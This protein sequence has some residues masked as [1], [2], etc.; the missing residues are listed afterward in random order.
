MRSPHILSTGVATLLATFGLFTGHPSLHAATGTWTDPSGGSWADPTNW[1]GGLIPDGINDTANFNATELSGP[2]VVSLHGTRIVGTLNL[3]DL[4]SEA[5]TFT[6]VGTGG[7]LILQSSEGTAS[8]NITTIGSGPNIF[9]VPLLLNSDTEISITTFQQQLFNGA[10]TGAGALTI[11]ANGVHPVGTASR[12]GQVRLAGIN[13]FTG[14][15]TI[16][17]GVRVE[18][19]RALSYGNGRVTV[20]AGGQAFLNVAGVFKNDFTLSGLGWD[21]TSN[22]QMGALRSDANSTLTGAITLASSTV[23][24]AS[25]KST[26]T[27]LI[28]G[29]IGEAIAGTNLDIGRWD[30]D[31]ADGIA[32]AA[33]GTFIISSK[34][35]YTGVTSISSGT[36]QIGNGS[37]TGDLSSSSA[38]VF[39]RTNTN[40]EP[41]QTATL[42]F[43]RSDNVLF[44]TPVSETT[45]DAGNR[46]TGNLRHS[47]TGTLSWASDSNGYSGTTTVDGR[48]GRLVFGTGG[49]FTFGAT[50]AISLKNR[51]DLE[52]NTSS[53]I[54]LNQT[55]TGEA[56]TLII[57]SGTGTLTIGG[58]TDNYGARVLVNSG[59]VVL[60]KASSSGIHAVTTPGAS[61]LG[62]VVTGGVV[63]LA[64]T[65]GNQIDDAAVVRL[66]GGTFDMNG[67][68]EAFDVLQGTAG[69]ITNSSP[70]PSTLQIGAVGRSDIDV[71]D[72]SFGG[73][74]QDGAGPISLRKYERSTLTLTGHNTYTGQT[75][76]EQGTLIVNGS[77]AAPGAVDIT[78]QSTLSG[79]GSLGHVSLGSSARVAPGVSA[80]D[81]DAGVLAMQSL[82]AW[83]GD[84][85]MDVGATSDR[86]EVAGTATFNSST[87]FAPVFSAVPVPGT[88][89]LLSA[90]TL[91][92]KQPASLDGTDGGRFTMALDSTSEPNKLLLKIS[93]A[94]KA[95][96]W[97]GAATRE[98]DLVTS[99][100][101]DDAATERFHEFDTVAFTDSAVNRNV[102][103]RFIRNVGGITV[104]NS[105]GKDYVFEGG[106]IGGPTGIHKTGA[107]SLTISTTNAFTGPVIIDGGK[108]IMG[109]HGALG[110]ASSRTIV[111]PGGSLDLNGYEVGILKSFSLAGSGTAG[112]GALVNSRGSTPVLGHIE[113]TGNATIG[114]I[115]SIT[116]G[117]RERPSIITGNG[118]VLTKTGTNS[119]RIVG[120]IGGLSSLGGVTIDGGALLLE[121][122][123]NILGA[124]PVTV[125]T[126]G[127]LH[128]TFEP[129][130]LRTQG[131]PVILN[132]GTLE[133]AQGDL[134]WTGPITIL[135][136]SSKLHSSVMGYTISGPLT[137]N[138]NGFNKTGG[139]LLSLTG[140]NAVTGPVLISAGVL[141]IG[142]GGTTGVITPSSFTVT[143]VGVLRYHLLGSA[144]LAAN[145]NLP[146]LNSMFQQRG[147]TQ[148]STLSIARAIGS[149]TTNGIFQVESGTAT[150]ISGGK[151]T[152]SSVQVG[153]FPTQ[154]PQQNESFPS[155]A[156]TGN[157]GTLN[158]QAG[159]Q[160]TTDRLLIGM[161]V[162][163]GSNATA[164][165]I[166][167]VNQSGGS[168]TVVGVD[169]QTIQKDGPL[170]IGHSG[171]HGSQYNLSGGTLNV[172]NGAV[173]IG[174]FGT[175]S[176]L[177]ISGGLATIRRLEIDGGTATPP[178]GGALTLSGG[179]LSVGNGGI[180]AAGDGTGFALVDITGGK[181]SASAPSTWAVGMNFEGT[182]A[183]LDTN[184]HTVTASGALVGPGGFTKAG[185]GTLILSNGAST[186]SSVNV[187]AGKLIVSGSVSGHVTVEGGTL[188]GTGATGP[189]TL[190]IGGIVAPGISTGFLDVGFTTFSG[191]TLALEINGAKAGTQ[192][193]QL[194][195]A[196]G[197][198]LTGNTALTLSLGYDPV[199]HVDSFVIISN[200]GMEPIT[201]TG[202][203]TYNSLLLSEGATFHVNAQ[204]FQIT[205]AGGTD[206]NDVVLRAIPEPASV[207]LIIAML[208][209]SI[210]L[211]RFRRRSG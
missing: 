139:E 174:A 114:G 76:L 199:D 29:V 1:S 93:G 120:T 13:T 206:G 25:S 176:S 109:N 8:I 175:G 3:G 125:N 181:L 70:T 45:N 48:E 171:A 102:S 58:T 164:T 6:S 83:G 106:S 7:R 126:G 61:P 55:I 146:T 24:L 4:F 20:V 166:G 121:Q 119:L 197:F 147:P 154:P 169:T 156:S 186:V 104:N 165:E 99:N 38:I 53:P 145:V 198:Q 128:A 68:N 194:R 33:G 17:E 86:V 85:R 161:A 35:A 133:A 5:Y 163:T 138:G 117:N 209:G 28:T 84:F 16:G 160:I 54:T 191:G 81:G 95:L 96:T 127:T 63:Q 137:D 11:D 73:V 97:T 78:G 57:Q 12:V 131:N 46:V 153:A 116:L 37:T 205:Y 2:S 75:R 200:K 108:V 134:H 144:E 105:L 208:A 130:L 89:T 14:G 149:S 115:Q 82:V 94:N 10:I 92:F 44:S 50:G 72:R 113:L 124:V 187:S 40:A 43:N 155:G 21:E 65:G 188:T 204:Q 185:T 210:G 184:A 152:V 80:T 49:A 103:I 41:A 158:I 168:V 110:A 19:G 9:E 77:L 192:Y 36:L 98:W 151:V 170:R 30:P 88:Y 15:L 100:W 193:D 207:Y 59:K 23:R 42:V 27:T 201:G 26:T 203:F 74:I 183:T 64:G 150:V 123:D 182:T 39:G 71:V 141:S 173:D 179:E 190:N 112:E 18:A 136:G 66:D 167:I 34:A 101:T 129:N 67:T 32:A 172:P 180:H 143:G 178:I 211:S 107:G 31:G 52:F 56:D 140:T 177:N 118:H 79:S 159:A 87:K 148:E 195:V 122:A 202:V 51:A 189:L 47:G 196:G 90:G 111:N 22:R 62:L 142:K 162:P 135:N 157:I 91:T 60:A 132:G 69:V